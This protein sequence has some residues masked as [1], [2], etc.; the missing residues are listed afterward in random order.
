LIVA[1]RL[2]YELKMTGFIPLSRAMVVSK[3]QKLDGN[4]NNNIRKYGCDDDDDDNNDKNM[5]NRH[6]NYH[7]ENNSEST[8]KQQLF[9]AN[10]F[11]RFRGSSPHKRVT[12]PHS[13]NNNMNHNNSSSKD[14]GKH[15]IMKQTTTLSNSYL[16][17]I[18]T[19]QRKYDNTIALQR[20]KQHQ[21]Q[22]RP[23]PHMYHEHHNRHPTI[24]NDEKDHSNNLERSFI[25]VEQLWDDAA[26]SVHERCCTATP[27]GWCHDDIV[28]DEH[29]VCVP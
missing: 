25:T 11:N 26:S 14:N 29:T 8:R 20:H 12:S 28:E 5:M 4:N 6:D 16:P 23:Q 2:L 22:R 21:Q 19:V 15:D 24:V 3:N 9:V 27:N 7:V 17:R 10:V 13:S 18:P 1:I